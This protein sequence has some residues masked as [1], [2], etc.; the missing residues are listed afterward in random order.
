MERASDD[1]VIKLEREV[2]KLQ[3]ELMEKDQRFNSTISHLLDN[4]ALLNKEKYESSLRKKDL[5]TQR[6]QEAE[7]RE[8][9]QAQH[10]QRSSEHKIRSTSPEFLLLKD[11]VRVQSQRHPSM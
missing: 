9:L 8:K 2:L 6:K 3:L 7:L 1:L 10:V 4:I 5:K 11:R